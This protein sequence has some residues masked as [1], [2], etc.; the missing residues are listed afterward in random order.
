MPEPIQK[1]GLGARYLLAV[2]LG[3]LFVGVVAIWFRL[4]EP[5]SDYDAALGA[6]RLKKLAAARDESGAKLGRYSI[7][8]KEKGIVRIPIGRAIELAGA[9]LKAKP[10]RKSDVNVEDPYPYGLPPAPAATPEA[11]AS[12]AAAPDAGAAPAQPAQA[13]PSASPAPAAAPVEAGNP[14]PMPTGQKPAEGG[15]QP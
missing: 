8:D 7:K 4:Q 6:E 2:A 11:A 3:L 14:T 13:Q 1:V 10:V 9:E 5:K 15:A 12:P